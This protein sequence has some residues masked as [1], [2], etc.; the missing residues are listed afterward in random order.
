MTGIAN[1]LSVRRTN[2]VSLY[3]WKLHSW[4]KREVWQYRKNHHGYSVRVKDGGLD[5]LGEWHHFQEPR[6]QTR[7]QLEA[8]I[9]AKKIAYNEGRGRDVRTPA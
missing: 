5:E 1:P 9:R 2:Q 7:S 8:F 4:R 3:G 6:P